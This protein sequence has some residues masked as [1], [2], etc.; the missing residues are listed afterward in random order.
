M[1]S[2]KLEVVAEVYA[3]TKQKLKIV[4]LLLE[5]KGY[6][7]AVIA[8][9]NAACTF[10]ISTNHYKHYTGHLQRYL[11]SLIAFNCCK[12]FTLHNTL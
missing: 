7:A 9:G 12:Q 3:E 8:V 11:I 4:L 5:F 6:W 2:M 10:T 1:E